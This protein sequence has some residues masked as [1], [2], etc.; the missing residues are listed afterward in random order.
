MS[1]A[2]ICNGVGTTGYIA[3]MKY[4]DPVVVAMVMLMEP[5]IALFQGIAVGVTT[6]PGWITWLGNAIV[7]SGSM[8]VIWSGSKKTETIDAT[9][10]LLQAENELVKSLNCSIKVRGSRIM[11]SPLV[12]RD[13]GISEDTEFI[14]VRGQFTTSGSMGPKK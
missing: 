1:I 11:K 6:L 2:I 5:C 8:L 12:R 14:P 10:A 4:F 9:D 7:I 13:R 3:I